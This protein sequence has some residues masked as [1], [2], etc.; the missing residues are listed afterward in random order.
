MFIELLS[1]KFPDV[2][3]GAIVQTEFSHPVP[4]KG[5]QMSLTTVRKIIRFIKYMIMR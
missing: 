1:G 5:S 2:R 3:T 4:F